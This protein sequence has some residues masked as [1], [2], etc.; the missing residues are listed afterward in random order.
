MKSTV[1]GYPYIGPNRE[2]K[3]TIEAFWSKEISEQQF[4]VLMKEYRLANIQVQ[5]D[6]KIDLVT[7]GDFTYYDRMLDLAAMFGII[8]ARYKWNSD[9]VSLETYYAMARGNQSAPASEMT[10]WFNT[11]YHYIVPEYE[12]QTLKLLDNKPLRYYLEAKENFN[13]ELKPTIIGPGTFYFLTKEVATLNKP[14][15]LLQLINVYSQLL[16]ELS[17]AGAKWIQIEEPI[18]ST[19]LSKEDMKIISEI[20]EQLNT[21]NYSSNLLLQTYF[22]SAEWYE[23][24]IKLPVA[25]IGLDF[26]HGLEENIS[27]I[28]KF[29]FPNDKVLAAGI[30]NGRDIWITPL[31]QSFKLLIELESLV[32]PNHLW[33][34]PS[35]SLM[36][37]PVS[38]TPETKLPKELY[39]NL[40]FANEKLQELAILKNALTNN[41]DANQEAFEQNRLIRELLNSSSVRQQEEVLKNIKRLS[42]I[43]I[44]RQSAYAIRKDRQ[45]RLLQLPD[46]PTTTIGS[47]PQTAEVKRNRSQLKKGLID[48]EQHD[49]FIKNEIKK[50]IAYQE[51]LE[52]DVLVHGEFERTDM[53]EYFGEK[54]VGFAF[55]EKAW[56]VSYGSRC[57]KPPIIYGDVRWEKPMTLDETV[58]AQSLTTK[59]VK[60]M[61]TGPI[62]I[63]N[64][65]FVRDDVP[66]SIVAQ[67]IAL[68]LRKEIEALETAGIRII[69]VDEPALREGLPLKAS[70]HDAYLD[71]SVDAF[72]LATSGVEDETQIHTHMCYCEFNDFIEPI[73]ALDADVISIETSKSHG[74]IIEAFKNATYTNSIGLG[75]YDIHSPRV[76]EIDEMVAVVN[77]SLE[78][79]LPEQCWINPDC[80]LKTR[81]TD[82]T[83]AALEIMVN[84]AKLLRKRSVQS[85]N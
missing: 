70:K 10:K 9:L 49:N 36:H 82:E 34:Q 32:S 68:A 81:K 39:E 53:V 6:A 38:L 55:T 72:K 7:V 50:W 83:L 24:L 21:D 26:V 42:E 31:Q 62:T 3:K 22:E 65:S 8:P 35:C 75:V 11:N 4:E 52:L 2:W 28:K 25:G 85:V 27:N 45:Q 56:V 80:G 77:D 51:E 78:V 84:T 1:I 19:S 5:L 66:R 48:K 18:L 63:L 17:A 61:L 23:E 59:P 74:E 46:F 15:Y 33:I 40:A 12:G 76:P 67:Q 47:F 29:G 13:A 69:Q 30:I 60:G 73:R 58:Y 41:R 43:Q 14:S 79:L 54:L 37:V 71:W 44:T 20:Y 16:S 64:W 57:V